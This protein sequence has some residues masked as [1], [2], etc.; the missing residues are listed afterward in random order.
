MDGQRD[1]ECSEERATA[2]GDSDLVR[3]PTGAV[4]PAG[5]QAPRRRLGRPGQ[6]A[7]LGAD[8]GTAGDRPRA[9]PHGRAQQEVR[10]ES[11]GSEALIE[12]AGY[13]A[14][15]SGGGFHVPSSAA[16]FGQ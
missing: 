2:H 12:G 14:W 13:W 16:G 11:D 7:P 6:C 10:A 8:A 1:E 5:G 4:W 3:S 15:R 9:A